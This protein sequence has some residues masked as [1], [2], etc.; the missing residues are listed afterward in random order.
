MHNSFSNPIFT[1][2]KMMI[3]KNP[4]FPLALLSILFTACTKKK[5]GVEIYNPYDVQLKLK[6]NGEPHNLSAN[7]SYTIKSDADQYTL[8]ATLS[9]S[10]VMDTT[11]NLSKEII[12]KGA[13][14]NIA[15]SEFYIMSEKYG[16][17]DFMGI[18]NTIIDIHGYSEGFF[19]FIG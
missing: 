3:M 9:D 5:E 10:T 17:P 18:T 12:E 4:V 1:T 19:R 13:L 15:G 7:S 16:G 2:P 6:V 11:F 8:I 14:I